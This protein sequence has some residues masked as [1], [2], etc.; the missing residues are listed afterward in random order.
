M[1]V[2]LEEKNKGSVERHA[3]IRTDSVK[4]SVVNTRKPEVVAHDMHPASWL[5]STDSILDSGFRPPDMLGSYDVLPTRFVSKNPFQVHFV[6]SAI[7]HAVNYMILCKCT[8]HKD[9][10]WEQCLQ[11][12]TGATWL[13]TP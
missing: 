3:T 2:I 10:I 13:L 5:N 11:C 9:I 8:L 6:F 12:S 7:I 4:G 1:M